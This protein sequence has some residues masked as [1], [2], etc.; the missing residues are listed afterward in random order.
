VTR[1]S[2][3]LQVKEIMASDPRGHVSELRAQIYRQTREF[4]FQVRSAVFATNEFEE[5]LEHLVEIPVSGS[6]SSAALIRFDRELREFIR[7]LVRLKL[8]MYRYKEAT[9]PLE[10]Q[11][12]IVTRAFAL[13]RRAPLGDSQ[14]PNQRP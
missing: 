8:H 5:E 1:R 13:D 12:M 7:T 9:R 2:Y 10:H 6:Y 4:N 11:L 14:R 3:R